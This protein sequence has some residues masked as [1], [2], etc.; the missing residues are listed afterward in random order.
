MLAA[1]RAKAAPAST[2]EVRWPHPTASI[3]TTV[4]AG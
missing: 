1:P 2:V 4:F 3:C